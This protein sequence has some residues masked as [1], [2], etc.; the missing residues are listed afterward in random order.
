[1][2]ACDLGNFISYG[3]WAVCVNADSF[4][5]VGRMTNDGRVF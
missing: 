1:M 2:F 3:P 5:V 4:E